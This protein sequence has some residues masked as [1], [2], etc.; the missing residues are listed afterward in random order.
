MLNFQQLIESEYRSA[1]ESAY[2]LTMKQQYSEPKIYLGNNDLSKRWYV[3]FSY[4]NPETGK[5]TRQ[6][7]IYGDANT[8]KTK[9]ERLA[10]LTIYRRVLLK[11]LKQGYSP[12]ED[13]TELHTRLNTPTINEPKPQPEKP[14][15]LTTVDK[16]S[17]VGSST[18][19]TGALEEVKPVEKDNTQLNLTKV[20]Q[21]VTKTVSGTATEGNQIKEAS[22]STPKKE[23]EDNK[24]KTLIDDAF[25][26]DD[27]I[28]QKS[29]RVT[30]YRTYSSHIKRFKDWLR[31]E[32]KHL[33]Y[34]EQVDKS[35]VIKYLNKVLLNSSARN[36]NNYKASISSFYST[37]VDNDVL[38]TNEIVSIKKLKTNSVRNKTYTEEQQKEIFDYLEEADPTL[39]LFIK[40]VSYNFLRPIE[41]CRLKIGDINLKN[42]T[43]SFKAKNKPLKTKIIPSILIDELPDLSQFKEDEFLFNYKKLG[44]YWNASEDTKRGKYSLRFKT[45]V[46]DKFNL[47]K[48]YGLYSFRHTFITK[49]YRALK[50]NSSPHEAKSQLMQITGHTSMTALESYLRDIDVEL[51]N[52]YS[53]LLKS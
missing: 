49:L 17:D 9:E 39:L 18:V 51:P 29:L 44:G 16:N 46:K 42:K 32:Q 13:N 52:D 6:T 35:V 10:V 4:R 11:L 41:V 30:S 2:D 15:R 26:L 38:K 37:L 27:R 48:E 24:G 47:G 3:Y 23:V 5:L 14:N 43:I 22:N 34:I 50:E 28:K 12:Y 45:V 31:K 25:N 1:Y 21:D 40:F 20:N 36:R 53:D 8:Y 7:P 19:N 33:K